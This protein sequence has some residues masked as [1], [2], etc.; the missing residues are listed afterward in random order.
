MGC[1][2]GFTI[3]SYLI[4]HML[5]HKEDYYNCR[6]C[7]KRLKGKR[8]LKL[9]EQSH[10]NAQFMSSHECPHCD[11]LKKHIKANHQEGVERPKCDKCQKE[12]KAKEY[13][14]KHIRF[15]HFKTDIGKWKCETC[16]KFFAHQGTLIVHNKIHFGTSIPCSHCDMT[17][18]YKSSLK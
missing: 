9:H 15:I 11:T 6:I 7:S 10:K 8:G 12:F 17:F 16:N 14:L 18:I 1:N 4:I 5:S 3:K 13:L 2:K